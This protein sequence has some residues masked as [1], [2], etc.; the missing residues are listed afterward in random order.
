MNV[1][2]RIGHLYEKMM[3]LDNFIYAEKLLGK[4]KKD[5]KRAQHIAR[6]A[7]RYGKQ[8]FEQVA[9][10]NYEWHKPK[11]TVIIDTW[12]G[13]ERHLKIPCLADQAAQLAWLNIA[14]PYIEK[15]NYYYNCGS[16]PHAGQTRCVDAL[17]KWLKNPAMK[18]LPLFIKKF[19]SL[20]L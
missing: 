20:E 10:G 5:N 3:C 19:C 4:N 1:M 14:T 11:E 9:S 6:H 17:K 13:K 8:L 2:K 12:K 16:M 15:R 18:Y 7:E